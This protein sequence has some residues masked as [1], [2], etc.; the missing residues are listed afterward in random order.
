[1][2]GTVEFLG[3]LVAMKRMRM[4]L[5]LVSPLLLWSV[6]W[7]ES[8]SIRVIVNASNPVTSM[9]RNQVSRLFLKKESRWKNGFR[10]TPVDQALDSPTGAAFSMT[11]HE[12][13]AKEIKSHWLK[14]AFS[15]LGT[16]PLELRSDA[17]VLDFVRSNV[18]AIGYVSAAASIGDGVKVLHISQ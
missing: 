7:A 3:N 14:V 12:K 11:V 18:G 2:N 4:L 8:E 6:L 10:V 1:M 9:T 5:W 13:K 16:P 15:G 17:Q